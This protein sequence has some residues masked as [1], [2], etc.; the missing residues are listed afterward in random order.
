M[1]RTVKYKFTLTVCSV[2]IRQGHWD[3]GCGV[4]FG[5]KSDSNVSAIPPESQT[6]NRA[7]LAVIILSVRKTMI[8]STEFS[9]L[10]VFSDNR[11]CVGGINKW[12]DLRETEG[13][14]RMGHPLE[15]ND[16]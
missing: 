7:E 16:L 10:V 2:S 9:C 3:A 13:W 11:L 4:W 14:A 5:D 6:N 15:K 8:W 1:Y 12:I